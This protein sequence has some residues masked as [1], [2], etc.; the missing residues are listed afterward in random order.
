MM[1][2]TLESFREY[3]TAVQGECDKLIEKYRRE[4]SKELTPRRVDHDADPGQ[5]RVP[6]SVES[7]DVDHGI[8]DKEKEDG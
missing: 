5:S 3:D 8:T 6:E 2:K 4:G 7:C 1:Q